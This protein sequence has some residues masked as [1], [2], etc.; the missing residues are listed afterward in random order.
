MSGLQ[1]LEEAQSETAAAL[2]A[3]AFLSSSNQKEILNYADNTRVIIRYVL[4]SLK[5]DLKN[6]LKS[7]LATLGPTLDAQARFYW[8]EYHQSGT[9]KGAAA[10]KKRPREE[11]EAVAGSTELSAED[12]NPA[13]KPK[14]DDAAPTPS[15]D[16]MVE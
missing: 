11:A 6:Q 10:K 12:D 4:P 14:L 7:V 16:K 2:V 13:K 8:T 15:G 5:A 3:N 1:L 9:P